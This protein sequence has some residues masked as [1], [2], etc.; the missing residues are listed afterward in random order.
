MNRKSWYDISPM[1][2]EEATV[3]MVDLIGFGD[4]P[5]PENW[6][7]TIE[8]QADVLYD[9]IILQNL[10][11]VVIAGHSYGGGVG[12]MLLLKMIENGDS[13]RIRKLILIAPAVYP[14]QLPFFLM[15]PCIPVIGGFLLK[16]LSAEFQISYTLRKIFWNKKAITRKKIRRYYNNIET[17]SHRNALIKTAQNIIPKEADSLLD[18]IKKIKHPKLLIYGEHDSVILRRNLEILSLT[19]PNSITRKIGYCGHVPHEEYPLLVS[20]LFHY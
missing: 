19:L 12:L 8:A 9:F 7:Y 1:V 2:A 4:S 17:S 14:Q 6:P 3:H 5:A 15:I 18:K 13:E 11:N 16:H 20:G 10:A